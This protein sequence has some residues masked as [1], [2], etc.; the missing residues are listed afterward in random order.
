ML[1]GAWW[2]MSNAGYLA[3]GVA[4]VAGMLLIARANVVTTVATAVLTP[5]AL[6]A[7]FVVLLA[8]PLP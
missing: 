5:V 2:L 8:T 4:L 6:W 3:G 7:L 1:G